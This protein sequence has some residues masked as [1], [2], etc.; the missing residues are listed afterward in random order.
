MGCGAEAGDY[1]EVGV[2][3]GWKRVREIG[4]VNR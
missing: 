2:E 1:V 4:G 3:G